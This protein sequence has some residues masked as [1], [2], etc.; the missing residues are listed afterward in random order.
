MTK[1]GWCIDDR[2]RACPD[3]IGGPEGLFCGCDCHGESDRNALGIRGNA[4]VAWENKSGPEGALT[5]ESP[6]LTPA[7]T[8]RNRGAKADA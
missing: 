3:N 1:F 7:T 8:R 6:A 5:P 4:P 2:H